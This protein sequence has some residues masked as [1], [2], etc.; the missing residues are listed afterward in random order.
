[1]SLINSVK[2]F[3]APTISIS[4]DEKSLEKISDEVVSVPKS[5]PKIFSPILYMPPLQLFA[6]YS[7]VIRGLNPDKPE[8]LSK[9]V[10]S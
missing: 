4:D 5:F 1:M 3:G 7:S 2:R 9:V 8:K 10:R 6:Y